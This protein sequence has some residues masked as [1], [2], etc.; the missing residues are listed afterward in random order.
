MPMIRTQEP[1][2]VMTLQQAAAYLRI[3]KAHLSNV[4]GGKVPGVQPMRSVRI[5]RRILIRQEWMDQWLE[6]GGVEVAH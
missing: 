2:T 3:S 4:I 5:G 1:S 6:K